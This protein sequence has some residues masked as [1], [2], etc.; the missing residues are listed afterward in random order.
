MTINQHIKDAATEFAISQKA[1]RWMQTAGILSESLANNNDCLILKFV[2]E[3]WRN[4]N[5]L[6]MMLASRTIKKRQSL[7]NSAGMTKPEAYVYSRFKNR[8]EAIQIKQVAKELN[9]YFGIPVDY[10]IFSMIRR[11]RKK[12]ENERQYCRNKAQS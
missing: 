2:S 8:T 4:D 10:R 12:V 9:K 6:K 3:I 5:F 7:A 11:I 1:I